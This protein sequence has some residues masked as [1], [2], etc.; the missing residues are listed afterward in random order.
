[1]IDKGCKIP[2]GTTIGVD[3]QE[4]ARHFYI[5]PEGVRVVT[6]EMLGQLSR[7]VR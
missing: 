4:D 2:D 6:P 1:V 5:S 3:E 7:Y